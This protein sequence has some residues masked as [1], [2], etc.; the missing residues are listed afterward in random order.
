MARPCRPWLPACCYILLLGA[1]VLRGALILYYIVVSSCRPCGACEV[2]IYRYLRLPFV[3]S[4]GSCYR[5]IFCSRLL[6]CCSCLSLLVGLLSVACLAWPPWPPVATD[7]QGGGVFSERGEGLT[8]TKPVLIFMRE[9]KK[10]VVFQRKT[11]K[12]QFEM[13]VFK[14]KTRKI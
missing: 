4:C 14:R 6:A 10:N 1:C 12:I 13:V 8:E 3:A 5:P 7:Q 2:S 9:V 11:G